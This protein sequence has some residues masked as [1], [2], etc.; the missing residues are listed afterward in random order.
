MNLLL[1]TSIVWQ[2]ARKVIAERTKKSL[3]FILFPFFQRQGERRSGYAFSRFSSTSTGQ[4]RPSR[5]VGWQSL[6]FNPSTTQ[7]PYLVCLRSHSPERLSRLN[8]LSIAYS[9][10]ITLCKLLG[11]RLED[12]FKDCFLQQ[13]KQLTNVSPA[14]RCCTAV[15]KQ[16]LSSKHHKSGIE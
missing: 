8:G 16:L 10:F 5:P 4:R 9:S 7:L 2:L 12:S 6:D 3:S 15:L 14:P 1:F 13:L 11:E